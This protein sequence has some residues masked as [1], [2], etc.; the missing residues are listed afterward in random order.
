MNA[1]TWY[2]LVDD[3]PA[4][5]RDVRRGD[6]GLLRHKDGRA[7][8]YASHGPRTRSVDADTLRAAAAVVAGRTSP[9]EARSAARLSPLDHDGNGR[10]GGS[11][12]GGSGDEMKELREQY[13]TKFGKRAFGGW[14]ADELRRR[15]AEG[16]D[17]TAADEK[18]PADD[19]EVK[20]ATSGG[21]Y[22]TR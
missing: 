11:T 3:N 4:D 6:D 9:N 17:M 5:P 14:D 18:S 7:V 1:E 13:L 16:R 22:R 2:V 12:S 15:L 21:T 20:P 8:A 19:R 10:P